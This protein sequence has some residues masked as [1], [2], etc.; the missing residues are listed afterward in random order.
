MPKLFKDAYLSDGSQV[1]IS[2][3]AEYSINEYLDSKYFQGKLSFIQILVQMFEVVQ[4]LHG[5][6]FVHRDIKTE[7]FRILNNSVVLIDFGLSEKY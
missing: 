7:N 1:L 4:E 3:Y 2:E 6:G 5:C